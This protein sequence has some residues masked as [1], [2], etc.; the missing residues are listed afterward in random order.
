MGA[1]IDIP[2][3]CCPLAEHVFVYV[4]DTQNSHVMDDEYMLSASSSKTCQI[5]VLPLFIVHSCTWA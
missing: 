1:C 5:F 2:V 3:F 4:M